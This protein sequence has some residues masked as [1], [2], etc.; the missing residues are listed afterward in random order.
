ML[1]RSRC[2]LWKCECECEL[3]Y[4]LIL[5]TNCTWAARIA[6]NNYLSSPSPG[7]PLAVESTTIAIAIANAI[8]IDATAWQLR[9]VCAHSINASAFGAHM[10]RLRLQHMSSGALSAGCWRCALLAVRLFVAL[11]Y[12]VVNLCA[13]CV[14]NKFCGELLEH[15]SYNHNNN[16]NC[17]NNTH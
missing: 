15:C 3:I 11:L 10:P 6:H 2:S 16:N 5:F 12:Q 4:R 13:S 9:P 17:N 7:L 8:T 14:W 1:L